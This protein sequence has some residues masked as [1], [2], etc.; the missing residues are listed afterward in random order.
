ME[1]SPGR[2]LKTPL[3]FVAPR[4]TTY[5]GRPADLS[6]R[7]VI[8]YLLIGQYSTTPLI[9][10]VIGYVDFS[11]QNRLIIPFCLLVRSPLALREPHHDQ[12]P[13]GSLEK[14][15]RT[16]TRTTYA[17]DGLHYSKRPPSRGP[18]TRAHPLP[19]KL[20]STYQDIRMDN[21]TSCT[22]VRL[23]YQ[24]ASHQRKFRSGGPA[25]PRAAAIP[26]L[27]ATLKQQKKNFLER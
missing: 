6:A 25:P 7:I 10:R 27:Q 17:M 16:G 3:V 2:G 11:S 8:S 24:L 23:L 19:L 21:P 1:H 4:L 9:L 14:Y 26:Q 13:P 18:A 15:I 12:R 20:T 22:A 5:M